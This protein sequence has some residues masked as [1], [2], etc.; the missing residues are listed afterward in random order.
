MDGRCVLIVEVWRVSLHLLVG[1]GCVGGCD[2]CWLAV[3]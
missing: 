3:F 2:Y 1:L